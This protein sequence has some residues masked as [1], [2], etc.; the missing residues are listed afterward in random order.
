MDEVVAP[1]GRETCELVVVVANA[2]DVVVDL[3]D[4]DPFPSKGASEKVSSAAELE[5]PGEGELSKLGVAGIVR[6]RETLRKG[7]QRAGVQ[8]SRR[9]LAQRFMRA[10]VVEV[11]TKAIEA[12]LL[13]AEVL[14]GRPGRFR[15]H[16]AVHA[17]VSAILIRTTRGD[18]LMLDAELDP[19]DTQR[20]QAG[21]T[22]TDE[23]GAV[24]CTDPPRAGRR[25]G[26]PGS[27][28]PGRPAERCC[29]GPGR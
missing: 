28:Q 9:P 11:G 16:R 2:P 1:V 27:R 8:G 23:R 17:F 13:S 5:M 21:Q 14:F 10:N 15:L 22:V 12:R 3:N 29:A 18:P 25:C 24:V 26:T 6:L 20:A 4:S 19:P 7:P